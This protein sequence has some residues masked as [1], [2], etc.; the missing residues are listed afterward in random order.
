MSAGVP[1]Q[2]GVAYTLYIGLA[3]QAN[4]KILQ[5]SPTI[6]AGDIK[7]S[8]NGAA[9]ANPATLPAVTPAGGRGVKIS[10]SATEM[11]CDDLQIVCSDAAGDEWCDQLVHIK[12]STANTDDVKA[13]TY[14]IL[15]HLSGASRAWPT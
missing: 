12:T 15:Q 5:V 13:D 11:D 7:I 9:L 3:S 4:T 2:K 8:K 14:S 1:P 10:L 6:A